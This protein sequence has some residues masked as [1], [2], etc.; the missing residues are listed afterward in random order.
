MTDA[1]VDD[2]IQSLKSRCP[3][4]DPQ[5]YPFVFEALD[6]AIKTT[7]KARLQ[8]AARHV[9]GVEL[10]QAIRVLARNQFGFLAKTVL[11]AWGIHVTEDFGHVVF[12]M[13]EVDLLSKQDA[14][15]IDDFRDAYEFAEAF[16][17]SYEF[18]IPWDSFTRIG[19]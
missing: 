9:T 6:V 3:R 16:E 8:G 13:V 12:L 1:S 11:N 19:G 10:L 7:G 15:S 5:V 4:F 18:D 14:D 2:K 17:E